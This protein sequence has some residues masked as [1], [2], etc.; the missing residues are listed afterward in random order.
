MQQQSHSGWSTTTALMSQ[1]G[2]CCSKAC[3]HSI[4][5]C[6]RRAWCYMCFLKNALKQPTILGDKELMQVGVQCMFILHSVHCFASRYS[7]WG[8]YGS[9]SNFRSHMMFRNPNC[10]QKQYAYITPWSGWETN[11]DAMRRF[12][13]MDL[14][15]FEKAR[16][17]ELLSAGV[18]H[19]QAVKTLPR[20]NTWHK[21]LLRPYIIYRLVPWRSSMK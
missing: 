10:P 17:I 3:T 20:R 19:V 21:N 18:R 7:T 1:V 8:C 16:G 13:E 14:E 2:K 6:A 15:G 4:C 9:V 11:D 5:R 12:K